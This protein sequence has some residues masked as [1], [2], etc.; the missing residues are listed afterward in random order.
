MF[1]LYLIDNFPVKSIPVIAEMK[2]KKMGTKRKA[3]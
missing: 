3:D 2:L 1:S